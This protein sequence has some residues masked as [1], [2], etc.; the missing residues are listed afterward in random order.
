[1]GNKAISFY[2]FFF[3]ILVLVINGAGF[4]GYH[5]AIKLATTSEVIVVNDFKKSVDGTQQLLRAKNLDE[6]KSV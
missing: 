2:L 1:M 5:V 6:K 4:I 3:F